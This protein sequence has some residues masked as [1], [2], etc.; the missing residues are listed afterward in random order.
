VTWPREVAAA[1]R[2]ECTPDAPMAP[3]TSIRVGGPADLLVR[4]ADAADLAV[5]LR[6]C[7][8]RALPVM[9]LGGAPVGER[10]IFWNFVSSSKDRLE[11]AKSDWKN[12]RMKLPDGDNTEFTP[13]PEG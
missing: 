11:Q 4:P 3:R 6:E 12:G 7:A 10:F 5:L 2:G 8:S 9:V 13:L 1:V